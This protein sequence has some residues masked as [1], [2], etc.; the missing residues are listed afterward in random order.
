[1]DIQRE[2][3]GGRHAFTL[4]ELLVVIAIIGILAALLLPALSAGKAYAHSASCKNH[5]RQM[6]AALQMYVDEHEHKYPYYVNPFDPSLDA[7]VGSAN[8]RYWWAKLYPYYPVKWTTA[9]YHCPGYSGVFKGEDSDRPPLGS[10]AYNKWGVSSVPIFGVFFNKDLGLGRPMYQSEPHDAVHQSE[11]TTPSEMLS[12]G[13]SRF[14][15]AQ[16]NE[17]GGGYDHMVCGWLSWTTR[18]TGGPRQWAFDPT[19]HGKKYNQLFCDGHVS[20]VDPWILFN[21]TNSAP[22]WNRDHQ[23]HPES[24]I[25]W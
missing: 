23:P 17:V 21:P 16:V 22:M 4:I 14:L 1:M 2:V 6:G 9:A 12:I 25:P 10:Y 5:L 8:T 11:I 19:R 3:N 20:S 18:V 15:S 13:E 24:W 7:V